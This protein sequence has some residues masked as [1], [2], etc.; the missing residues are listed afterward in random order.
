MIENGGS[1]LIA[2]PIASLLIEKY[3]Q[4]ITR[5]DLERVLA[6]SLQKPLCQ[7]RIVRGNKITTTHC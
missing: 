2:G 6:T 5:V 3:R 1:D 7:I 4:K